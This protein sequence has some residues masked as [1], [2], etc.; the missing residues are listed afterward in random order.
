MASS[1]PSANPWRRVS[2]S[3]RRRPTSA[4]RAGSDLVVNNFN[5]RAYLFRNHF[6]QKNYIAFRLTGTKC[7]HDAIGARVKIHI[8]DEVMVRQVQAAGGYL[9][10]SS[11]TLHFGLGDRQKIDR[12]EIIWPGSRQV[13]TID[14]PGDQHASPHPAAE[15][16]LPNLSAKRRRRLVPS[17][18][19]GRPFSCAAHLLLT[20]EHYFHICSCVR[21]GHVTV[22]DS[23]EVG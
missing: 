15:V 9:S 17:P 5:N 7:N 13:Q 11:K 3:A 20:I 19:A 1:A 10:Q 4:D 21:D 16:I 18:G 6:P 2:F 12:A 22:P 14:K 8:G 23:R